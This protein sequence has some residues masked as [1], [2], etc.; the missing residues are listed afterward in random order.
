[1]ST[2]PFAVKLYT[3]EGKLA[4]G[5]YPVVLQIYIP[6]VVNTRIR[7]GYKAKESQWDYDNDQFLANERANADLKEK[8][9]FAEKIYDTHFAKSK[10]DFKRFADLFRTGSN[11]TFNT[12]LDSFI[13]FAKKKKYSYNTILTYD[14][15]LRKAIQAYVGD[16]P[17]AAMTSDW[18]ETFGETQTSDFYFKQLKAIFRHA[19]KKG[20]I[21]PKQFPFESD[22]TPNG[23]TFSHLKASNRKDKEP[24]IAYTQEEMDK[25]IAFQ[26]NSG[27]QRAW[28][29]FMLSYYTFGTNL[30]DLIHLTDNNVRGEELIFV[31]SKTGVLVRMPIIPEARAIIERWRDEKYLF[32]VVDATLPIEEKTEKEK[33]VLR[34][35]RRTL[36]RIAKKLGTDQRISFYTARHTAATIA[37]KK[38]RPIQEISALL[39]H[40]MITTSQNYLAQFGGH[41]LYDTMKALTV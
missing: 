20:F 26:P 28:D 24:E 15:A 27:Q 1:M 31:R 35:I 38:G 4:K 39:G 12:A 17:L 32:P 14:S 2:S 19:L 10:F 3:G 23:Y 37:A 30:Y 11:I 6:S 7:L 33:M 5:F 22:Y 40:R 16:I 25:F 21:E 13:E 41:E 9:K 18:M 8:L 36:Q 29:V 34:S